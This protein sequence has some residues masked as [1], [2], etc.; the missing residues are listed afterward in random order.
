MKMTK[1]LLAIL[2]AIGMIVSMVAISAS[3]EG[4]T[5]LKTGANTIANGDYTFSAPLEGLYEIK[6]VNTNDIDYCVAYEFENDLKE[7]NPVSDDNIS[8][9][10]LA[11]DDGFGI[12]V[13]AEKAIEFDVTYKGTVIAFA[14][15][16]LALQMN[17]DVG[18]FEEELDGGA[19]VYTYTFWD[20]VTASTV[21]GSTYTLSYISATST[22]EL[23]FG[24]NSLKIYG[25]GTDKTLTF[26]LYKASDFVKG[27]TLKDTDKLTARMSFG[28]M[29][30]YDSLTYPESLTITLASG[31]AE[32]VR[33]EETGYY[34][35]KIN[36]M[37]TVYLV[38]DYYVNDDYSVEFIVS[39]GDING[40]VFA[41]QAVE[42]DAF[43]SLFGIFAQI[44]DMFGTIVDSFMEFIMS[45]VNLFA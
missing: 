33:N 45:I 27:V 42:I 4:A 43:G 3:A 39:D 17:T 41:K 40:T 25:F 8:L 32:A 6:I 22:K 12:N 35:Y 26:N 19:T 23:G 31:T 11:K 18:L 2:L 24:F 29:L 37:Y 36:D 13:D 1:K 5:V 7:L 38:G 15:T 14:P 30:D 28:G 44:A 16:K 21:L 9:F 34:E 20:C 10:Y